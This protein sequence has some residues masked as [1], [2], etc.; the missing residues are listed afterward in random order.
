MSNILLELFANAFDV[1]C[2]SLLFTRRL[3]SKY[4]SFIPIAVFAIVGFDF[5]SVPLFWDVKGY[6]TEI[7][8][9]IVSISYLF[10]FRKGTLAHKVF[11]VA[12]SFA[13]IFAIAFTVM[14]LLSYITQVNTEV[15][16]NRLSFPQRALY[17]VVVNII[18][19][20]LFYIIS[21]NPRKVYHNHISMFLC[22]VIPLISVI[23]AILIHNIF[24]HDELETISDK[25]ILIIAISYML[26]NVFTF[27]LYEVIQREA[28]KTMYLIAKDTQHETME[29]YT[30]QI[31]E[32]NSKIRI[33]QH[34]MKEHLNCIGMLLEQNEIDKAKQYFSKL[35]VNVASS[36]LIINSGNSVVDAVLSSKIS[37]AVNNGIKVD[38]HA[39]L[40]DKILIDEVDLCSILSNVLENAIEAAMKVN[41]SPYINCNIIVVKKQLLIDVENSSNGYYNKK[42]EIFE[43]IKSDGIHGLGLKST[44]SIVDK[45][46]GICTI[47]AASTSFKIE[48]YIPLT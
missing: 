47:N 44:R 15:I 4:N 22:F 21:I 23:S 18:K 43:T 11:W 41:E 20:T 19:F 7:V 12:V 8:L 6:P 35:S 42:G 24:L 36:Y 38:C 14:P 17:L 48:I 27:G 30:N 32:I 1:V 29:E 5:E 33:W 26:I 28:E 39:S 40:P 2:L 9:M 16:F 46:E 10:F 37:S 25:I 45:Y 34:D 31:K 3:S 13:L